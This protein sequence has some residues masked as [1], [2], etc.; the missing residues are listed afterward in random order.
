VALLNTAPL[1]LVARA[2]L[3][4]NTWPEFVTLARRDPG[5][6]TYATSGVGTVLQLAME[7]LKERSGIYVTHVPYRGGS[8]IVSDVIGGQVDLGVLVS[9]SAIPQVQ[10]GRV[11]ALGVTSPER[12]EALPQVPAFSE[13]PRLKGYSLVSWTGIFAPA[14]TPAAIVQRLNAEIGKA[15]ADPD[16]RAKMREQGAIPGSGTP[17]QV[18]SFVR[19]EYERYQEI[20]RTAGI[21]A[22]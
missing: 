12:L 19:S 5:H 22:E 4:A 21:K 10:A 18:G 9:I 13:F 7:L 6:Y 16:V 3:P 14:G 2:N 17:E 15:L 20:V 11:K 1:V 8:Q